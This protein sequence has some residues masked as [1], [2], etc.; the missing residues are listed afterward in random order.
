MSV[1]GI[2]DALTANGYTASAP[3]KKTTKAKAASEAATTEG[4]VYEKSEEA[5]AAQKYKPNAELIA[6]LKADSDARTQQFRTLVEQMMG[7]QGITIGKADDIWSFL[8]GGNYTVSPEVKAQAQA[9]IAEDGYWGVNQ[10]SDRIIDFAKALTGGDPDKIEEMRAAFE[11]GFKQA[12]G[13][14]GRELPDISQKTYQ[15]VM[16]KFDAWAEEAN[17][18]TTVVEEQ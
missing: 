15:A 17:G 8:A 18:K 1:N 9:D 3:A 10:T 2:T 12:T 14:W 11:K 13:T 7:K 6:K 4:V 16:D 5:K